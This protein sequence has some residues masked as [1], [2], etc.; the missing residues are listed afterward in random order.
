MYVQSGTARLA[1]S[2]IFDC[3]ANVSGGGLFS[4]DGQTILSDGTLIS[5]CTAPDGEGRSLFL[6]AG[7]VAYAL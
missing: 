1:R 6:L 5:G 2:N 3:I 7:D 4:A